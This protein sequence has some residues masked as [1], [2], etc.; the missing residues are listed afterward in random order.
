MSL[1]R[2]KKGVEE[3]FPEWELVVVGVPLPLPPKFLVFIEIAGF[4]AQPIECV[5]VAGKIL[6]TK[7]LGGIIWG[8]TEVLAG[9]WVKQR[10]RT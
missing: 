6:C 4:C 9:R 10:E 2:W 3:K 8:W 1:Y 5:R 7:E